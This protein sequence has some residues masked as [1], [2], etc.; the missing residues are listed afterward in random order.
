M[1]MKTIKVAD[2]TPLQIN[3][4]VAKC[5]GVIWAA[6]D[7][8]LLGS[9]M[10]MDYSTNWAQGG[11]VKEREGITSGPWDTSPAAAH[12]GTP[13]T[14]YSGNPRIVGPTDLV[15]SM[16]CYVTRK[17]GDTAEVPEELL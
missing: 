17:M 14:V 1:S 12:Y 4:L 13:A 15:A 8:E 3:W 5:E 16:R 2:A 10:G 11:P 9:A 6:P 7:G